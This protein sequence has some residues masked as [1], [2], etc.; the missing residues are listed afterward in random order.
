[1]DGVMTAVAENGFAIVP[2]VLSPSQIGELMVDVENIESAGKG[3]IRNLLD[4]VPRVRDLAEVDPIRSLVERVLGSSAFA[5]RAILFDKTPT[6]NW[7]V[8]WHQDLTIS[9]EARA[10]VAGFG[11]WTV[12]EGVVHVQPPIAIL[13]SMLAVRIHLDDCGE[14]NGPIRVIPGSHRRGRLT[15]E[16][17]QTAPSESPVLSCPVGPGGV[18]LMRPLLLHASSAAVS[19]AHRRV[20]H[21]EFGSTELPGGLR[22]AGVCPRRSS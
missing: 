7:K 6:T 8:P 21:I 4:R 16:Q 10:D 17:I 14:D 2:A 9:V 1:M 22:Y 13:E 5:S 15:M 18:L 19:P 20:I 12:K 3:G 11:P